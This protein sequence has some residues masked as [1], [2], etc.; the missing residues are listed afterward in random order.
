MYPTPLGGA[1]TATD[2]LG[3]HAQLAIPFGAIDVFADVTSESDTE[4]IDS[5][6]STE[7]GGSDAESEFSPRSMQSVHS[8]HSEAW[9]C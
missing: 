4:A 9:V 1:E 8:I 5:E 2:P 3:V 6:I 7:S